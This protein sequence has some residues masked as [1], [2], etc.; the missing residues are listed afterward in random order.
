MTA[1]R[2]RRLDA[3]SLRDLVLD[4]GSWRSWD[5]PVPPREADDDYARE[6]AAA[7]ARTQQDEA[8]VTGEATLRGRRVAMVAGEF[9]FLAGSI[10]VATAERLMA[11]VTA[12]YTSVRVEAVA[13]ATKVLAFEPCSACRTGA[14]CVQRRC[15]M[16]RSTS[17]ASEP[18]GA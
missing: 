13:R 15:R 16:L 17:R 2:P 11:A 9:G 3:R 1:E 4:A 12:L 6:L 14:A 10:G 5:A 18:R 7:T 8:I